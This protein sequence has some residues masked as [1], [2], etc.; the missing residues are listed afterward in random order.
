MRLQVRGWEGP[1]LPRTSCR[2]ALSYMKRALLEVP[3]LG[4]HLY[5]FPNHKQSP[6][7]PPNLDVS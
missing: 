1:S 3:E 4:S 2:H 7:Q 6:H 5:I